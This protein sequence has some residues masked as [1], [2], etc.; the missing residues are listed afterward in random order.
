MVEALAETTTQVEP[1][2]T[3]APDVAL[4]VMSYAHATNLEFSGVGFIDRRGRELYV[5][6]FVLLNVG[7]YGYTEIPPEK[8]AQLASTRPDA[9][10]MRLWLH[11]HPIGSGVPGPHNWSG[12]DEKTCVEEPLGSPAALTTWAAAIVITPKGW[13]GRLDSFKNGHKTLHLPVY[14]NLDD[15]YREIAALRPV[16][17][18]QPEKNAAKADDDA[19]RFSRFEPRRFSSH[20]SDGRYYDDKGNWRVPGWSEVGDYR[21]EALLDAS[22]YGPE[23]DR[24]F[25]IGDDEEVL[26]DLVDAYGPSATLGEIAA[27]YGFA[28]NDYQPPKKAWSLKQFF[29]LG[30][31]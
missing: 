2:F 16:Y 15:Y 31:R 26:F 17:N 30:R 1:Y 6:D 9:D 24:D 7:S 4:R 8:V 5:Y 13:V 25:F 20:Q 29:G 21:Q 22:T 10:K 11:R 3:M 18:Y 23:A 27:D 12:T 19:P 28:I 14:P